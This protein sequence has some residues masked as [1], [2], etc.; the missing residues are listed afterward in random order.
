MATNS[1]ELKEVCKA[2]GQVVQ[3]TKQVLGIDWNTES[4]TLW[5]DSSNILDNA[6]KGPITK[7]L[8]LQMIAN[9]T[10]LWAYFHVSPLLERLSSRKPGA[11][12]CS[13]RRFYPMI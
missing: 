11:G 2:E 6:A 5:M 4:D 10:T 12:A 13:G 7:T 9:S 1:E 3:G 8:L